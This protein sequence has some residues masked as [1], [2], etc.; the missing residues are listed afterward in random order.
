MKEGHEERE[1]PFRAILLFG[2]GLVIMIALS[3]VAVLAFLY[4]L[5]H[6]RKTHEAPL[7]AVEQQLSNQR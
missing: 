6:W 4:G 1:I 3:F 7:S 5:E 2:A